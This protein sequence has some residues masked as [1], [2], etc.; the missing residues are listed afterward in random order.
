MDQLASELIRM[1]DD[2]AARAAYRR[3]GLAAARRYDRRT[4]A[5]EMLGAVERAAQR[6]AAGAR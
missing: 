5:L 3:N 1:R 2:A 6:P 4:L